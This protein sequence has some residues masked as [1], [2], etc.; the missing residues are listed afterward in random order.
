MG[1][2]AKE[3]KWVAGLVNILTVIVPRHEITAE[4]Q[5]LVRDEASRVE[6]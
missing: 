4:G 3:Y 6:L 1:S 5:R 2:K